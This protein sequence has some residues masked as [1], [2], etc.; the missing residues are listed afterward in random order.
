MVGQIQARNLPKRPHPSAAPDLNDSLWKVCCLCWKYYPISRLTMDDIS[1]YLVSH[2]KGNQL[3]HFI[4]TSLCEDKECSI[5]LEEYDHDDLFQQGIGYQQIGK[6]G[7]SLIVRAWLAVYTLSHERFRSASSASS[8]TALLL[9]MF[10]SRWGLLTRD[11][12]M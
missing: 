7:R 12:R 5:C 2:T 9:V 11:R 4:W 1:E 3:Q 6:Y 8:T 10:G